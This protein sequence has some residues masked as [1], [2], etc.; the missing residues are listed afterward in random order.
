MKKKNSMQMM[1]ASMALML[2]ASPA[3]AQKFKVAKVERTRILVD[4][5][6]DAQPDAE[7]AKF[8]A[9][10]QHKVDSIMG[11]VVGSVAHDMTR[12][13]PESE[14]SNL[15]SDILVWGGRQF[16]E[17]PVFSVYNMGGIRADFAKGD[18][19]V[20]DVSEVAPFEN[21]ICFLTL[22]GEKV[23]ELFQQIAYRIATLDYLAEGNDQLV[24]FK[25]GT[26]VVAPKAKE[27]NVRYIIMDYFREMK[28]QGKV[29]ESR[30]EGRCVVE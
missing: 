22:T 7:A 16:N 24:A 3:F 2:M 26:D 4:K 20:G 25:S 29:V 19:N 23:L 12:H 14:L 28:A 17:Q 13:R 8:I 27:N 15:L 30:V 11:P 21:K 6:W 9:P 10:Y 18:I 1:L 5:K